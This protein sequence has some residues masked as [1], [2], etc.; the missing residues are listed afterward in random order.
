MKPFIIS[1]I[2]TSDGIIH[3]GMYFCPKK[4]GKRAMLWIHGL[5]SNFYSSIKRIDEIVSLCDSFGIG[6]ASFN[7]RG[8]DM[9]ASAHRLDKKSKSGY[10]YITIGSG[11]EQFEDSIYDVEAGIEFLVTNGFTEVFLIGSSTG[12]N[13]ACYYSAMQKNDYVK[14]VI[15]LSPLSDRLAARVSNLKRLF[16]LTCKFLGLGK[17]LLSSGA[18]FPGT[19]NRFLSLLTP[20]SSED[21]FDYGDAE[22]RMKRFSR[23]TQPLLVLFGGLDSLADRD[24]TQIKAIFDAHQRSSDY[25]SIIIPETDHGFD[26]KEKDLAKRIVKWIN[27]V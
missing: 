22:P 16:L 12:A 21:V 4:P 1:E 24:I 27:A 15:L 17:L 8:H 10:S 13:K 14:G 9:L 6:L 25:T 3:Q 18:Y 2:Q 11:I 7:N 26:G 5:T 20:K 19:V 23:I